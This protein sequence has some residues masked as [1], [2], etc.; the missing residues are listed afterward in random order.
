MKLYLN[1]FYVSIWL[2]YADTSTHDDM[3]GCVHIHTNTYTHTNLNAEI[4]HDI[5]YFFEIKLRSIFS[6][7]NSYFKT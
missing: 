5:Q 7:F 3:H 1:K 4:L 2:I 6:Y